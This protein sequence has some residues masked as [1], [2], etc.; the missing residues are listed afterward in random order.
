MIFRIGWLV[1]LIW[2]VQ[3]STLTGQSAE[4]SKATAPDTIDS[5]RLLELTAELNF[6]N[7]GFGRAVNIN[8]VGFSGTFLTRAKSKSYALAGLDV[9]YFSLGSLSN[10]ILSQGAQ[11][12]DFTRSNYI[13][14]RF[15]YRVYAPFFTSRIE[16]FIEAGLGPQIFYTMTTTTFLDEQGSSN[17]IVDE[18]A[19]GLTY[20]LAVGATVAVQD[21]FFAIIKLGLRGGTATNF[22]HPRDS[23]SSEY[24]I[25]NFDLSNDALSLIHISL[26]IS[27]SF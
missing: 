14:A 15:L 16:P 21:Q 11:F 1:L 18:S 2:S 20:G 27:Y 4:P 8:T 22:L 6:P 24:P 23:L 17:I 12:T 13:S 3:M 5:V 10:T 25:D 19:L 7:L 26:G 9:N